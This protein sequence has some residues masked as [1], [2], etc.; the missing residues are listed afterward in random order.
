MPY[1]KDFG[2]NE[3]NNNQKPLPENT[4]EQADLTA[5]EPQH[6]QIKLILVGSPEAVRSAILHF[7][8]IG[9]AQVD[10]WSRTIPS[11]S[12]PEEVMSILFRK[13][14]VE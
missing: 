1:N 10:D 3:E 13:I 14:T 7:H 4:Q 5:N 6:Q 9:E 8:S 2:A 12:N 11:P